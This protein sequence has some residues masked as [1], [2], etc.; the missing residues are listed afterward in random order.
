MSLGQPPECLAI[1]DGDPAYLLGCLS[2]GDDSGLN[3]TG[4]LRGLIEAGPAPKAPKA[5][6]GRLQLIYLKH[7]GDAL[8][9][10]GDDGGLRGMIQG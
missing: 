5:E 4:I 2:I 7:A 8:R 1:G 3:P 10:A 9:D 6:T